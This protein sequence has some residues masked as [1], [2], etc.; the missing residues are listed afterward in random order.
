MRLESEIVCL[1]G[2]EVERSFVR[3]GRGSSEGA[4]GVSTSEYRSGPDTLPDELVLVTPGMGASSRRSGT[5]VGRS[6]DIVKSLELEG[7]GRVPRGSEFPRVGM[8]EGNMTL[9]DEMSFP[10]VQQETEPG[11]R[12]S[13]G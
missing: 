13:E 12:T 2:M 8:S 6:L 1:D 9:P 10:L 7:S 5:A 11:F 3:D 4:S